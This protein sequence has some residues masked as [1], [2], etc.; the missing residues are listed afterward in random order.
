MRTNSNKI[1]FPYYRSYRTH[2]ARQTLDGCYV[3][4][5][6]PERNIVPDKFLLSLDYPNLLTLKAQLL[7]GLSQKRFQFSRAW[8]LP[9]SVFS[10]KALMSH[11]AFRAL[12]RSILFRF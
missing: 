11:R 7:Y 12:S 3:K 1:A 6:P 4:Y 9:I 8:F 5:C 2:P 10:E